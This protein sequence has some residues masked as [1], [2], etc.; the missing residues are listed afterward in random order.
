MNGLRDA[1]GVGCAIHQF[2]AFHINS[3]QLKLQLMRVRAVV[4]VFFLCAL[5][6]W[7]APAKFTNSIGIVFVQVPPGTFCMGNTDPAPDMD[8]CF[9]E[10]PA[11]QVT[12]T[13]P[14]YISTTEVTLEQYRMF[15]PAFDGTTNLAPAAAGMSWYEAVAFCDWLSQM[16]GKPYR[17][18]T[19]A[20]WEY[21]ARNAERL[22][23]Q[24]MLTDPLEW[25]YDWHGPYTPEPKTNPVGRTT[26]FAR[27]VR[28]GRLDDTQ[29]RGRPSEYRHITHR[30]G[31]A[32]GFGVSPNATNEFGKHHIGFRIV[33]AP[34]YS[35]R[36]VPVELNFVTQCVRQDTSRV[37]VGPAQDKPYFRKRYLLPVPPDNAPRAAIDAAGFPP[38]FRGHNH[39][40]ALTVC[41]NGDVLLVLYTSYTEYEPEVS[42]I[43]SR[44]R[45]GADE[46]DF[47]SPLIDFPGANDHAPLLM[48]DAEVIRLFWGNPEITSAFPF[49]WIES[50]DNGA[51]WG[52]VRFPMFTGPVGPH[53]RQLINSAFRNAAGTIFVA[54]DAKGPTSVLWASDD[55]GATWYDT[56]GR[57]AGRHTAFALLSDGSILG[58]GGKNTHIDGFMPQV[59]SHDGGRTWQTNK[60]RFPALGNNQRPSLLRLKSGRL[61]YAGDFQ[62]VRGNQPN[63]ITNRGCFVALSDDDGKTW[64]IK[65]LP[66][67]QPHE[68]PER[69]AGAPT[70]GYSVAA[71][72]PNGL[73]H[74]VTSM[75][76]PC[77]HFE[78]NE[79]WV[80]AP[81]PAT[82]EA[83]DELLMKSGAH[84]IER[85]ETIVERYPAG[86]VR[87][88]WRGG[89]A[90]DGRWLMHGKQGF[91][92]PNGKQQW[93]ATYRL[94]RK[95][96]RETFW[97]PDGTKLW[98]WTHNYDG[99]SVWRQFWPNGRK[100]IESV[101]RNF[102]CDGVAVHWNSAGKEIARYRFVNGQLRSTPSPQPVQSKQPAQ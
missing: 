41:P 36:P 63:G 35:T 15:R 74:L 62:D 2:F 56:G 50:A 46:W 100:K 96:G 71:Q 6:C 97:A 75:N 82:T 14:F 93:V 40:P 3:G 54:S 23:V 83:P 44:L 81:E 90:N 51:T 10:C 26:G 73:I 91:W 28:G 13:Q 67:A 84:R 43:A 19:E 21:V 32:P 48:T 25:C 57:S 69:V 52:E 16:E 77:L 30:S 7:G 27:V 92:Y 8:R 34:F 49:Q 22:G 65:P 98:E 64:R 24:G 60:S 39:S 33:Q 4:N 31:I 89:Q 85:L 72:A 47:P 45:F 68:R 1:K 58:L 86:T 99:S 42:L 17:L 9:D 102:H 79:A 78:F 29:K 37:R 95:V 61:F 94:G 66:G 55:N 12:L 11:H 20:E 88:V 87:A 59:I 5:A 80:L 76:Q 101:W 53:D 70:L 18:P 38:L